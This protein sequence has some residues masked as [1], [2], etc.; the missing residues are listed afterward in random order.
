MPTVFGFQPRVAWHLTLYNA[1]KINVM[2]SKMELR[3]TVSEKTVK[4]C[5]MKTFLYLMISC[6]VNM[7][8]F[9]KNSYFFNSFSLHYNL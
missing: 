5:D 9:D 1:F 6:D 4:E 2:Q 8:F 7:I 3:K